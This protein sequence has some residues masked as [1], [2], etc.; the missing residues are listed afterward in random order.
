MSETDKGVLAKQ[1]NP[2]TKKTR[3]QELLNEED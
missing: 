3:L 1:E 2:R